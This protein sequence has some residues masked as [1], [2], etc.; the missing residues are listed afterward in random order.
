MSILRVLYPERYKS[1]K[2][3]ENVK[4]YEKPKP[5]VMYHA[6]TMEITLESGSLIH[7]I[8]GEDDYSRGYLALCVFPKKHSYFV[9]SITTS[10]LPLIRSDKNYPFLFRQLCC[11]RMDKEAKHHGKN[12]L[13]Y[14]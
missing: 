11:T 8:A 10:Y 2:V 5:H 6:D 1:S 9:I 4:G 14:V 7:Q 12:H 13:F 3:A